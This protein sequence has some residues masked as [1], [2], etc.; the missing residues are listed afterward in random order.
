MNRLNYFNPYNSKSGD[1]EDQLTRAYLALLR[2]SFQAF[3][4]FISYLNRENKN[5]EK[6]ELEDI[7]EDDWSFETQ[8]SDPDINS[9][10]LAS[11]L[12]TDKQIDGK[13]T[14]EP[15]PRSARYDG[16][17]SI[18]EKITFIIE[19]KPK[20][21][22]VW[23]NQLKPSR[24][25]LGEDVN[26]L[27]EPIVLEWK[28]IINHLNY[29]LSEPTITRSEKIIIDDFLNFID[30]GFPFL[31][32]FDNFK[33][34]K[35][36]QELLQRRIQNILKEIS[37]D[38]DNVK[39]NKRWGHFIQTPFEAIKAIGLILKY[40]KENKV[41]SIVLSLNFG[42]TQTQAKAFFKN[43]PDLKK[44]DENWQYYPKFHVS[45]MST[46]LVE[47]STER[48]KYKDYLNY[49]EKNKNQIRQHKKEKEEVK[50]FLKG[51]LEEGIINID[52]TKWEELDSKFFNTNRNTLNI[53]P[54]FDI[55]YE[56][57]SEF[58]KEKDSEGS[59]VKYIAKRIETGLKFVGY[60]AKEILKREYLEENKLY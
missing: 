21:G 5:E 41:W 3:S 35:S 34:C 1:H 25:N 16:L 2:I 48:E 7:L 26:V 29:L 19:N 9:N 14:V 8:R 22:N 50:L 30:S 12:I 40:N 6:F 36:N 46:N 18:G 17:I 42:D 47:F 55:A 13:V 33:L 23:F 37:I 51:L 60:D 45:F 11:V 32:P 27:S 57:K 10:Y 59:L 31:N 52:K 39:D 38:P 20:S 56:L 54:G 53:C 15:S 49:W 28:T 44:I 43:S 4:S 58:C 24:K